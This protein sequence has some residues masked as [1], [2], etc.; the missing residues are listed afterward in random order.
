MYKV[1]KIIYTVKTMEYLEAMEKR[2]KKIP[3]ASIPFAPMLHWVVNFFNC[4]LVIGLIIFALTSLESE[5]S[6]VSIEFALSI[7][8]RLSHVLLS[9]TLYFVSH[10]LFSALS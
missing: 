2:S 4:C 6:E 5:M 3:Q 10:A 8:N 9:Y 7:S 1:I